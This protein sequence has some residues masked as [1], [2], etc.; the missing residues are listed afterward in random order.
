MWLPHKLRGWLDYGKRLRHKPL[1]RLRRRRLRGLV[2]RGPLEVERLEQIEA[3]NQLS[4]M[5]VPVD[6]LD[7]AIVAPPPAVEVIYGYFG[8]ES[9]AAG[10]APPASLPDFAEPPADPSLVDLVL[11][12]PPAVADSTSADAPLTPR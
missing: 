9:S 3:P 5:S 4:A 11:Y 12:V 7:P 2:F 10:T 8:P 6:L 1:R